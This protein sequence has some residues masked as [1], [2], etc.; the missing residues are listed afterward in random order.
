MAATSVGPALSLRLSIGPVAQ[1]GR[2]LG[3]HDCPPALGKT[4]ATGSTLFPSNLERETDAVVDTLS[5]TRDL[6]RAGFERVKAEAIAAAIWQVH[7]RVATKDDL[8][9][10]AT[11][12]DLEPLAT[13][14]ELETL[15]T[16][17]DLESLATKA[18]LVPLATKA[19][20]ELLATKE[21]LE[22]LATKAELALCATK[23]CLAALEQRMVSRMATKVD[24]EA[25]A[26]KAELVTLAT[27]GD[28]AK[29]EQQ[30]VSRMATKADLATLETRLT[31]R[32]CGF[33]VALA[34]VVIA[35]VKLL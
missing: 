33:G 10:L 32:F 2:A 16:K 30:M 5:T 4:R 7:V 29:V 21:D 3:R 18:E 27:K 20:L 6:E 25:L 1:D 9:P 23:E 11:K 13:K 15:A 26:S 22:P 31:N 12:D 28:L 19:E 24:L 14:A 8:E 34:G 17:D 35:G